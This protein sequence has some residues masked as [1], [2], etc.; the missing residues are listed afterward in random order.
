MKNLNIAEMS[1]DDLIRLIADQKDTL[2]IEILKKALDTIDTL[3]GKG[4]TTADSV[5]WAAW[6]LVSGGYEWILL[7]L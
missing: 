3:E 6:N 1:R 5:M 7:S 4:K 2:N